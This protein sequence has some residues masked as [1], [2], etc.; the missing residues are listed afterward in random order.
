MEKV[1]IK[2]MAFKIPTDLKAE[3]KDDVRI[4]FRQPWMIGIPVIDK[5]L[6]DKVFMEKFKKDYD[7]MFVPKVR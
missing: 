1:D 7:L 6:L 4:V 2:E 3:F 5:M